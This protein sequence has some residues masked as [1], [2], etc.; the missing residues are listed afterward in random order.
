MI[1]TDD[2]HTDDVVSVK[3]IVTYDAVSGEYIVTHEI[4]TNDGVS[5]E[6]KVVTDDVIYLYPNINKDV[7]EQQRSFKDLVLIDDQYD[8]C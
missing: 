3:D 5:G 8:G 4:V 1:V 2:I 7:F 6:D